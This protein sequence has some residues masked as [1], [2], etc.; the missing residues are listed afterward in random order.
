MADP[1]LPGVEPIAG[2][3]GGSYDLRTWFGLFAPAKTSDRLVDLLNT[4][5]NRMYERPEVTT[6]LASLGIVAEPMRP[7]AFTDYVRRDNEAIGALIRSANL[8]PD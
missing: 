7:A 2:Q 5:I 3:T 4:E 1:L 8:K 6:R